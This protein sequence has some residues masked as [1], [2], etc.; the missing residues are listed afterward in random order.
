M[1]EL[2]YEYILHIDQLEHHELKLRKPVGD[3]R[4]LHSDQGRTVETVDN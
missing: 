1:K 2:K 4:H 3:S